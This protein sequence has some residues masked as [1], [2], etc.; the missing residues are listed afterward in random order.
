MSQHFRY[1]AWGD[2]QA[3]NTVEG[4]SQSPQGI[5][6]EEVYDMTKPVSGSGLENLL[7][8]RKALDAGGGGSYIILN[9]AF[10]QSVENGKT[11]KHKGTFPMD[12]IWLYLPAGLYPNLDVYGFG[13]KRA[14]SMFVAKGT[15][16]MLYGQP[17][18]EQF[19]DKL[20][21]H[22]NDYWQLQYNVI[23]GLG[24]IKIF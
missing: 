22:T 23:K 12:G 5:L 6:D 15:S 9:T 19:I 21:T 8:L 10:L 3:L 20:S 14:K 13:G 7:K 18:Y 11:G 24:S 17:M 1:N 16:F 4:F 2:I